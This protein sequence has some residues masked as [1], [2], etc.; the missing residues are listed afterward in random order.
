MQTESP[1]KFGAGPKTRTCYICGR[2]YGINS[3]E[4]HLK[5]CRGLW[6]AREEQKPLRERKPLPED[7]ML[8]YTSGGETLPAINGAPAKA[9]TL[10]ETNALASQAFNAVA[11]ETCKY[12]GRTFLAEK[13]VIHNRS[14]TLD[15][16]ARRV[17]ASVKRGTTETMSSTLNT[18]YESGKSNVNTMAKESSRPMTANGNSTLNDLKKSKKI[19]SESQFDLTVTG[20]SVTRD[21]K[22]ATLMAKLEMI[23]ISIFNLTKSVQDIKKELKDL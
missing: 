20:G 10:D 18:T 19:S 2:P 6:V 1:Q 11:L 21:Q 8:K 17:D 15:N 16:P 12:C 5:Q 13:L 3:Y 7:P 4:I 23:E 14:C 9:M 22:V